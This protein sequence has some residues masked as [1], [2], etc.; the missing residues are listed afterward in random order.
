MMILSVYLE[1]KE[2]MPKMGER[3]MMGTLHSRGI[4]VPRHRGC[5]TKWIQSVLLFD[6]IPKLNV[7]R[8]QCQGRIHYGILIRILFT[9][10][11]P[12]MKERETI[13]MLELSTRDA[14]LSP[15]AVLCSVPMFPNVSFVQMFHCT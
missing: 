6:G 7:N 14:A 12:P 2:S 1:V 9:A 3:M 8:T 15:K 10:V 5:F 11:E 13:I 4:I